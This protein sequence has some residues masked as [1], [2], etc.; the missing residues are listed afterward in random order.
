MDT[1]SLFSPAKINLFLH[2]CGQRND[3]FHELFSLVA[4][5]DFG[6][7]LVIIKDLD[8]TSSSIKLTCNDS[9][10]SLSDDN[11]IMKAVRCF[12]K[13]TGTDDG[14]RIELEKRIPM[15]A[16]LGGGSSNATT[17]LLGLNQ[18]YGGLL[19]EKELADLS[20][21][22]GSDCPLFL[23]KRAQL[24]S[25]RGDE[26]ERLPKV[27]LDRIRNQRLLLII[28]PFSINTA[29]AYDQMRDNPGVYISK[30]ESNKHWLK[31]CESS[32][33]L[34]ELLSNN[35]EILAFRKHLALPV[36]LE[37]LKEEFDLN[38]GM[39]GSGSC[40]FAL[41][42]DREHDLGRID[43][44]IKSFCGEGFRLQETVIL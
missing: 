18:L 5:L 41:Y 2:I 43:E 28:P 36:L 19:E 44:A 20:A 30:A 9:N 4:P 29:W 31:W 11:L 23:D 24:M 16:G 27:L 13:V 25:G 7:D 26:L 10:L 40:C 39:T 34:S 17:T 38:C 14:L 3:G 15:G 35:M 42:G 32:R 12:Q 8:S 1:I 22:L 21:S 37:F 6:D 33:P